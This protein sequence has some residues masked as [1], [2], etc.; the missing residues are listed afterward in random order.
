MNG[1]VGGTHI[2]S[3]VVD[4][5]EHQPP[6]VTINVKDEDAALISA[7]ERMLEDEEMESVDESG[8]PMIEVTT[9]E[10]QNIAF[11]LNLGESEGDPSDVIPMDSSSAEF[12]NSNQTHKSLTPINSETTTLNQTLESTLGTI[13]TTE[14]TNVTFQTLV[15]TR[16]HPQITTNPSLRK[17][18]LLMKPKPL[19]P[20]PPTLHHTT[21]VNL[22]QSNA[23]VATIHTTHGVPNPLA[24]LSTPLKSESSDDLQC[25][26]SQVAISSSIP[27]SKM[28]EV[29]CPLPPIS[30]SLGWPP[31]AGQ[32]DSV[33]FLNSNT[34]NVTEPHDS[35]KLELS[36]SD[37]LPKQR[38]RIFS[39]DFD[40]GGLDFPDMSVEI[41]V[42]EFGDSPELPPLPG[43]NSHPTD[44][45]A[46]SCDPPIPMGVPSSSGVFSS[47]DRAMSFEFF[48]LGFNAD[49]PLPTTTI[50]S[51]DGFG[52][53]HQQQ[54]PRGESI[55]FDPVSFQDGGIH[56][57]KAFFRSSRANSIDMPSK[58]EIAIMNAPG[59][60]SPSLSC[61]PHKSKD[62]AMV[63]QSSSMPTN[64]LH[65]SS[66]EQQSSRA[67]TTATTNTT[68][69]TTTT[70]SASSSSSS[71]TS[72]R[73]TTNNVSDSMVTTSV[74]ASSGT[75][76]AVASSSS[77]SFMNGS[78]NHA[79]LQMELLNKD[80]RIG[81][82]LPD[83]RRARIAK[84]HSK[85]KMR[86][87]RK[88][89]KYDCR[90]KLA[91]SRPRI[92]GR[93]V[94]RVDMDEED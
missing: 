38:G 79:T 2:I 20:P 23:S 83:A 51:E 80:G 16:S 11:V 75:S 5:C 19:P 27:L 9:I 71:S 90:K 67:I 7:E 1:K 88:R 39:M 10:N 86:I 55:I 63:Q 60:M 74:A 82:Y 52:F 72:N 34:G 73:N 94:K 28:T 40:A 22:V 18:P 87:W 33:T 25:S 61:S 59:F 77:S 37:L 3:H 57:E 32:K 58:D 76:M 24:S 46:A 69:T 84:F 78:M 85:R 64:S 30:C 17:V 44:S 89:I 93:F 49:E 26:S 48:S 56:D 35:S 47:R 54:R 29:P 81:I 36:S 66:S 8:H 21:R 53:Q 92:K 70:S 15:K 91:D 65:A 6:N 62:E 41:F 50:V 12:A 68:T 43:P 13:S 4:L 31:S 14:R 42:S 45:S